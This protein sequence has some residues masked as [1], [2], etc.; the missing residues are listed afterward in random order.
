M[1]ELQ[2]VHPQTRSILSRIRTDPQILPRHPDQGLSGR[3]T[4][5][6]RSE[7]Q[8]CRLLQDLKTKYEDLVLRE[9][10]LTH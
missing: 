2:Q 4:F 1:I 7:R 3:M 5:V 9:R 10:R 6:P 8:C